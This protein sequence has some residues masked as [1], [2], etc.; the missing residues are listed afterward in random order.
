MKVFISLP[1]LLQQWNQE[2]D[3]VDG[4]AMEYS[5]VINSQVVTVLIDPEEITSI[6]EHWIPGLAPSETWTVNPAIC[7]VNIRAAAGFWIACPAREVEATIRK[8]MAVNIVQHT[9]LN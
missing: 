9:P 8:A 7:F 2:T 6:E 3:F 1:R 4:K 5:A